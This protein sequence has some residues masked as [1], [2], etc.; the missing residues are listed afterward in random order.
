MVGL[1]N[2]NQKAEQDAPF[3]YLAGMVF[4]G[5]E[6]KTTSIGGFRS[7]KSVGISSIEWIATIQSP[8]HPAEPL[9]PDLTITL[10]FDLESKTVTLTNTGHELAYTP[11]KVF[12]VF[13]DKDLKIT[14]FDT[15]DPDHPPTGMAKA[16]VEDFTSVMSRRQELAE[17]QR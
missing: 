11:D 4:E 10:R 5:I 15:L 1:R 6:G 12:T 9:N 14:R 7:G 3:F 17:P 2:K 16:L 8:V 13:V